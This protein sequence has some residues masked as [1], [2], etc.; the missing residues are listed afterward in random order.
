M[1][2]PQNAAV[3]LGLGNGVGAC[4][5][6]MTSIEAQSD[7]TLRG[8]VEEVLNLFRGFHIG[9][10]MRMEDEIEAKLG[11]NSRCLVDY[12]GNILPLLSIER[13]AAIGWHA[14]GDAITFRGLR[15]RQHQ[16]RRVQSREKIAHLPNL[17]YRNSRRVGITEHDRN[18][19]PQELK[20]SLLQLWPKHGRFSGKKSI[21]SKFGTG[22]TRFHHLVE[23]LFVRLV[24]GG[25][26]IIQYAPTVGSG[27]KK[28]TIAKCSH[29]CLTS[30]L[31]ALTT[32]GPRIDHHFH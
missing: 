2:K 1:H 23:H 14:T 13:F 11:G 20:F 30:K 6:A 9:S 3:F 31:E 10:N 29:Y 22:V 15:V 16:E 25:P 7:T 17:F 27:C 4:E 24:P 26:G 12:L 18:K 21:G 28:K 5:K 19:R 32:L 8:H